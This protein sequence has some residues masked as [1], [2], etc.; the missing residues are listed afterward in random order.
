AQL[1]G[2]V[3]A[4]VAAPDEVVR[5]QLVEALA[6]VL[7]EWHLETGHGR[8]LVRTLGRGGIVTDRVSQRT[9]SSEH[10]APPVARVERRG[11]ADCSPGPCREVSVKFERKILL[12]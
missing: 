7:A 5:R 8:F 10:D 6:L 2:E 4:L 9:L 1:V 11:V 12:V 3:I